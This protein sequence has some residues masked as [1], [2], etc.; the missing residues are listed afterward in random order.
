[1]PL[2]FF[3]SAMAPVERHWRH[4]D[5]FADGVISTT[6]ML[7]KDSESVQ[8]CRATCEAYWFAACTFIPGARKCLLYET[9]AIE[10]DPSTIIHM[11][12][13]TSTPLLLES[14]QSYEAPSI[15]SELVRMPNPLY[16]VT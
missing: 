12:Q 10:W 6:V 11:G 1:M 3:V 9:M 4:V 15:N 13:D 8:T 2:C 5:G 7:Q 16:Y 14:C